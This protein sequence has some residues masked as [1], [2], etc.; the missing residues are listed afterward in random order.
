MVKFQMENPRTGGTGQ[1]PRAAVLV[2]STALLLGSPDHLLTETGSGQILGSSTSQPSTAPD[3]K[4]LLSSYLRR[5]FGFLVT[6]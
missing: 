6:L 3:K 5:L 1:G 2:H 4:L